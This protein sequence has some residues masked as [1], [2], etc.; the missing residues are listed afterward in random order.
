MGRL[1]TMFIVLILFILLLTIKN[2]LYIGLII[3]AGISYTII[4]IVKENLKG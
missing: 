4:W 1:L 3:L 2:P